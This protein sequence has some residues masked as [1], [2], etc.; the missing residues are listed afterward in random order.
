MCGNNDRASGRSQAKNRAAERVA[1]SV[2]HAA[3][4]LVEE[5]DARLAGQHGCDR[6]SLP[7]TGAEIAR[8]SG[9]E[10]SEA[11]LRKQR[12]DTIVLRIATHGP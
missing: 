5:G 1:S 3:S 10:M 11:Q 7:F 9:R 12:R 8:V 4:W 2:I 6:R